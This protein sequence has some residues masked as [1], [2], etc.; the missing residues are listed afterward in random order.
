MRHELDGILRHIETILQV[1][2]AAPDRAGSAADPA[3]A[4]T[5]A[6]TAAGVSVAADKSSPLRP[7]LP[8]SDA[9]DMPPSSFAPE[10]REGFFTVPRLSSHD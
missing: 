6:V 1:A 7:D 9:L 2:A 10:W 3:V 4:G 8:G 5:D